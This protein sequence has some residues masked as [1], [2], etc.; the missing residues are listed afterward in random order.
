MAKTLDVL[1][2][3]LHKEHIVWSTPEIKHRIRNYTEA[4][5]LDSTSWDKY[6]NEILPYG[7]VWSEFRYNEIDSLNKIDEKLLESTTGFYMFILKPNNPIYDMPK[8]VLYVGMSG[9]NNSCRPLKERL[10]DYFDLTKIKKRGAVIRM[11]EKYYPNIYIAFTYCDEET[12]VLKKIE[13]SLIGFFCPIVNKDD[14]PVELK[15][16]KKAF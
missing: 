5:L 10:K 8:N 2:S 1:D 7:L 16:E 13:T 15:S 9:E 12:T 11:L 6:Y 14:F 4:M 3:Y